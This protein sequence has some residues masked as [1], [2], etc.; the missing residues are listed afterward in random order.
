MQAL[1]YGLVRR[2]TVLLED[3]ARLPLRRR[4]AR[5][6]LRLCDNFGVAQAGG[7]R[8]ALALNQDEIAQM[9][10]ASRQRVNLELKLLEAAGAL[11]IARELVVCE[12]ALLEAAA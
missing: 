7:I 10:R 11:R 2:L 4:I 3:L 6:V 12:R 5:C 8:I 1:G 9:V